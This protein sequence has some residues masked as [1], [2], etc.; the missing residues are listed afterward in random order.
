MFP[1]LDEEVARLHLDHIGAKLTQLN[2][3]A[4]LYSQLTSHSIDSV[5][6]IQSSY[7]AFYPAIFITLSMQSSL[8]NTQFHVEYFEV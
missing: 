7:K 3:K 5:P 4:T 6:S 8:L 2:T 1:Q